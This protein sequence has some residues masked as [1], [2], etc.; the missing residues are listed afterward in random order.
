MLPLPSVKHLLQIV[1]RFP[2]EQNVACAIHLHSYLQRTELESHTHIGNLIVSVLAEIGSMYIAEKLFNKL[3]FRSVRTWKSLIHGLIKCRHLLQALTIYEK[4]QEQSLNAD[5]PLYVALL[6]T[7]AQLRSVEQGLKLHADIARQGLLKTDIFV[8]NTLVD[9]YVKFDFLRKAR[10]VF[11][12]LLMRDVVSWN[13]L[14]SGYAQSEHSEEAL[15]CLQRMLLEGI[16]PDAITFTSSL[17]ACGSIRAIGKGMEVHAEI[18]KK[19]LCDG[20]L[21]VGSSLVDMYARCGL[22]ETAQEVFDELSDRDVVLWTALISG[23]AQ[24]ELGEQALNCFE[25]MQFE[26]FSPNAITLASSLKACGNVGAPYKGGEIHA[27]VARKGLL[28]RDLILGTALV[29]MYAKCGLLPKALDVFDTLSAR[30]IVSWN[31]LVRGY[32]QLGEVENVL[33]IFERMRDEGVHSDPITFISILNACSHAGLVDK[34]HIY[35]DIMSKDYGITP[36]LEHHLCMLDLLGRA[37]QLDTAIAMMKK[38]PVHPSITMWRTV[39]GAC[40]KWGDVEIGREAFKQ[41]LQLEENEAG[42]YLCMY[43]VYADAG[44]QENAKNVDPMDLLKQAY[45]QWNHTDVFGLD[46]G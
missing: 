44:M 31:A 40:R 18:I 16:S 14:I 7:C 32:A 19:G 9:M 17:K 25:Q 45:C 10:E 13:A 2:K 4:M 24:H 39:L 26:G 29:D 35:F 12:K 21:V 6:R 27:E 1:S 41:A 11:D 42:T 22:L 36:N 5:G 43:N 37:G 3:V 38:A 23:Y 34:G 46:D 20:D 8:G 28:K 30:D 15:H 33:R